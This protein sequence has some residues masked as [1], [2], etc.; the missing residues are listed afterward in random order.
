MLF[1]YFT[2]FILHRHRRRCVSA[3]SPMSPASE[4][5]LFHDAACYCRPDCRCAPRRRQA[6]KFHSCYGRFTLRY[7]ACGR[8]ARAP[9]IIAA[10]R[11]LREITSRLISR[12]RASFTFSISHFREFIRRHDTSHFRACHAQSYFHALPFSG[13]RRAFLHANSTRNLT[14]IS[15]P[16]R[17]H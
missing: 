15:R 13:A 10:T 16:R 9:A 5:T 11:R 2:D 14:F 7:I 17:E 1:A 12:E 4:G 6:S 8:C 3:N